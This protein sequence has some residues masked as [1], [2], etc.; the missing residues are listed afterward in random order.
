MDE[1]RELE[2]TLGLVWKVGST[3]CEGHHQESRG[4]QTLAGSSPKEHH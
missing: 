4:A 3:T 1:G 2:Q